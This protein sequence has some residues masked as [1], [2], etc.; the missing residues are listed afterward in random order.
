[1]RSIRCLL[2]ILALTVCF[3]ATTQNT[4]KKRKFVI[5]ENYFFKS[6]P[7]ASSQITGMSMVST[8]NGTKATG[9]ILAN[10]LPEAA[11]KYAVPEDSVPEAAEL[12]A[13]F[14]EAKVLKV[15]TAIDETVEIGSKFPEFKAVDIDGKEWSTADVAGKPMVLNLWFT[16]CGPCRSEMPE[17][18]Q[19]KNEMPDIMFFSATYED[20]D[21][22]R[23]VIERQGF[24]WIPLVNDTQF[25]EWIGA[26]GYPMTIVVDKAG[27]IVHVEYGT[28]PVQ[29]EELKK[30]IESVR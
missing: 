30:I 1:M 3:I 12:K 16:G 29:R 25:K 2:A 18:S 22:A 5:I 4:P 23:P 21:R 17:L 19:W 24:N 8:P 13:R 11:L 26:Q 6:I 10:P 27:T 15:K 20:A 7:V 28:S 14:A 9:V